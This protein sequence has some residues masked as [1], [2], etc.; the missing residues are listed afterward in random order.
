[1]KRALCL[2]SLAL[3]LAACGKDPP[4]PTPELLD[5]I[6]MDLSKR[7]DELNGFYKVAEK[8][9]ETTK[10]D[11]DEA[12]PQTG[13]YKR[14][15]MQYFKEIKDLRKMKQDIEFYTLRA[16]NRQIFARKSYMKA[17]HAGK[18]W[19][20]LCKRAQYRQGRGANYKSAESDLQW[21]KAQWRK[22]T[23]HF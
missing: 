12:E 14:K 6:Y 17:Y 5:P 1:M 22:W 21:I 2:I 8:T 4:N 20:D 7:R 10:K 15:R 19:P 16:M 3:F 11:M 18:P 23:N 9:L 13:K